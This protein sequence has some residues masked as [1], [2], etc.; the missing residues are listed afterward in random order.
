MKRKLIT[1]GLVVL[2]ALGAVGAVSANEGSWEGCPGHHADSGND[3]G[4]ANCGHPG[5]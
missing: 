1:L 4:Q 2:F 3:K 5:H